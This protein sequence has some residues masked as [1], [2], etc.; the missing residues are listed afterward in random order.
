[1]DE[2]HTLSRRDLSRLD[3]Q[4]KSG[5][6]N[7]LSAQASIVLYA[8][9]FFILAWSWIPGAV[10]I[11]WERRRSRNPRCSSWPGPW[12]MRNRLSGRQMCSRAGPGSQ[13]HNPVVLAAASHA[14]IDVSKSRISRNG[15]R[16]CRRPFS[17]AWE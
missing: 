7:G 3:A 9:G 4:D 12:R 2:V 6:I 1:M 13:I 16:N 5:A 11:P 10:T 17:A 15:R 8:P 14:R